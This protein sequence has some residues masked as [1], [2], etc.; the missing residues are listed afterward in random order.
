MKKAGTAQTK[1]NWIK[2]N[3]LEGLSEEEGLLA[4]NKELLIT[5]SEIS[6]SSNVARHLSLANP[7][8]EVGTGRP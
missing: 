7:S 5:P 4:V 8:S 1:R 3:L 6:D 2:E